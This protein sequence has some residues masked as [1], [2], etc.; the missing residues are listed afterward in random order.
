MMEA[1]L[2]FSC[3]SGPLQPPYDPLR[4]YTRTHTYTITYTYTHTDRYAHRT[5]FLRSRS[6]RTSILLA[7]GF[8]PFWTVWLN[9]QIRIVSLFISGQLL[10]FDKCDYCNGTWSCTRIPDGW[11][12]KNRSAMRTNHSGTSYMLSDYQ[13]TETLEKQSQLTFHLTCFL[14]TL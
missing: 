6:R 5:P 13:S 1:C 12:R 2:C 10:P 11:A 7:R 3:A 9:Q 4:L 8:A 14:W